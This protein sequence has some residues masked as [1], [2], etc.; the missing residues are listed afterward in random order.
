M[1][2][3]TKLILYLRNDDTLPC[4][5]SPERDDL[6]DTDECMETTEEAS[7]MVLS[8]TNPVLS[9]SVSFVTMDW[10]KKRTKGTDKYS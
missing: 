2:K 5:V 8:V 4:L 3:N 6:V 9:P 7:G 1:H 10:K